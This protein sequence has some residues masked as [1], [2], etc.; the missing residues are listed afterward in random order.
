MDRTI[1]TTN[2]RCGLTALV[3]LVVVCHV[4]VSALARQPDRV[5]QGKGKPRAVTKIGAVEMGVSLTP[6]FGYESNYRYSGGNVEGS[7][8]FAAEAAVDFAYRRGKQLRIMGGLGG[9]VRLPLADVGLTEFLIEIPALL[10]YRP[11]ASVELFVSNHVGFERSR[12]PPVFNVVKSKQ[13]ETP[14]GLGI[15]DTLRPAL[16]FHFFPGLYMEVGPYFRYKQMNQPTDDTSDEDFYKYVDVGGDVSVKYIY[17]DR[18]AARVR[19]DFA[20]RLFVGRPNVVPRNADFSET[21]AD[22]DRLALTRM[23]A[24]AYL[25]AKVWGPLSVHGNYAARLVR[26]SNGFFTYNEHILGGGLGLSWPERFSLSSH[27]AYQVR[28]YLDR[29]ECEGGKCGADASH[30]ILAENGFSVQVRAEIS[31]TVWLAAVLS[32]ELEDASADL[33]DPM[34]AIHR[35][36]G[37]VNFIL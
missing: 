31:I 3:L 15:Y 36:L 16:A 1:R 19:F 10:F 11:T 29:T 22:D 23:L 8:M 12:I 2:R 9:S 34:K 37:G 26:D 17:K 35:V 25:S 30:Q 27:V 20:R 4:P 6:M 21:A 13:G 14:T 7:A 28:K 18:F 24:G 32:Y 33:E 5:G